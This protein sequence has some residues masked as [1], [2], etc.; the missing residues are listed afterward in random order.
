[1][2][3]QKCSST[4]AENLVEDVEGDL[5]QVSE[6]GV[7]LPTY[8]EASN[9]KRL[10]EEIENLNLKLSILVV[11]DSSPDGTADIVRQLQKKYNNILLFVRPKKA[12]LGSAIT[13]GF[14]ILLS[15][16]KSPRYI[17]TMDADYSHDPKDIP[18][19]VSVARNENDLVIGSRYCAGGRILKWSFFRLIVSK[20]A[21][22]LASIIVRARIKDYTS[23]LRCYSAMLIREIIHDLH[24]HTYEIQ[25]E[26]IKQACRRKFS[27]TEIPITFVNR[28]CGKSKL[29][30]NEIRDFI[31]YML[32]TVL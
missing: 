16:K 7:I 31:S 8:C 25:I 3:V 29:S 19:L 9:I 21:N 15:L 6:I 1:M 12:G 13:D 28:K 17:V 11:D 30:V 26:T 24:S 5:S 10:I 22:E 20:V 23:G 14:K 18:L 32:K 4:K 2:D 27:I